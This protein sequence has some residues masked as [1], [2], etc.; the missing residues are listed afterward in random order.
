MVLSTRTANQDMGRGRG[1]RRHLQSDQGN[2]EQRPEGGGRGALRPWGGRFL[3]PSAE[4]SGDL[5]GALGAAG[6]WVV[7][8]SSGW[9]LVETQ[10]LAQSGT[11]ALEVGADEPI[12]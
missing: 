8:G 3:G 2:F 1:G 12:C 4:A 11:G 9:G 5:P 10:V 6:S 7:A